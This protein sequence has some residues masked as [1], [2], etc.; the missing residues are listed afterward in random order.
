MFA[1]AGAV[2][3]EKLPREDGLGGRVMHTEPVA[4][5]VDKW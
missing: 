3:M 5:V 4:V 1:S 2:H